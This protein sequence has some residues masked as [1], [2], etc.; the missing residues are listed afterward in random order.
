MLISNRR[1]LFQIIR[2]ADGNRA[3]PFICTPAEL[4]ENIVKNFDS[5]RDSKFY[6]LVLA[7]TTLEIKTQDM[8]SKFPLFT[9]ESWTNLTFANEEIPQNA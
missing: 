5:E 8:V 3:E 2:A 1:Y 6:V 9:M 7:D 4:Q